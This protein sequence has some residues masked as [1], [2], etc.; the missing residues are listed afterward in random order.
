MNKVCVETLSPSLVDE[1]ATIKAS[2]I[3]R[4]AP[5]LPRS[6]LHA[7]AHDEYVWAFHCL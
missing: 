6:A 7:G 3:L 1:E 2:D 5:E 4:L